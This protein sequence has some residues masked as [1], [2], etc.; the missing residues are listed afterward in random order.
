MTERTFTQAEIETLFAAAM[1]RCQKGWTEAYRFGY[2]QGV[3]AVMIEF[4]DLRRIG[5]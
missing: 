1:A 3:T 2:Q 5:R 4:D